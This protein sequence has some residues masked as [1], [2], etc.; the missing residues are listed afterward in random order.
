M[1]EVRLT[2]TIGKAALTGLAETNALVVRQFQRQRLDLELLL[3]QLD[4]QLLILLVL[5]HQGAHPR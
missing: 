4:Q 5:R 2:Q 1:I 3:R